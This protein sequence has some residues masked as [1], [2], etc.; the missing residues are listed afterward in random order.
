MARPKSHSTTSQPTHS[1]SPSVGSTATASSVGTVLF[2]PQYMDVPEPS[3]ISL[4]AANAIVSSYPAPETTKNII[5][6]DVIVTDAGLRTINLFLD[7]ILHEFLARGKST[8]L[9]RLREA[10]ALVIR[11]ALGTAAMVEAEQ[12]LAVNLHD[13]DTEL[14][15]AGDESDGDFEK[16]EAAWNLEKVWARA[17]V[18]CMIYSTLGDKEEEDFE[19][20]EEDEADYDIPASKRKLSAAGAIYLIAVLEFIGEHCFI[21]AARHAYHR[22][23]HSIKT[24]NPQSAPIPLTI[25][26]ADVKR[27]IAEDDL[28]TRLWRK[29]KRSEKLLSTM[30]IISAVNAERGDSSRADSTL[31]RLPFGPTQLARRSSIVSAPDMSRG[32]SSDT[33]EARTKSL[34]ISPTKATAEKKNRNRHSKVYFDSKTANESRRDSVS[35]IKETLG[36]R[37]VTLPDS[38]HSSGHNSDEFLGEPSSSQPNHRQS[39]SESDINGFASGT[40]KRDANSAQVEDDDTTEYHDSLTSPQKERF[41]RIEPVDDDLKTPTLEHPPQLNG[42]SKTE[43]KDEDAVVV[44]GDAGFDVISS[45]TLLRHSSLSGRLEHLLANDSISLLLPK[46]EHLGNLM[47]VIKSLINTLKMNQC[48]LSICQN[49]LNTRPNSTAM[50][51]PSKSARWHLRSQSP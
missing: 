20:E 38:P 14:Y 21:V 37:G 41:S 32:E 6:G 3:Y 19:E 7:Y 45:I 2:L 5:S 50:S 36:E 33:I 51:S 13:S 47:R 42:E 15:D 8:S 11:T 27:G 43:K 9:Y 31:T 40:S 16:N 18:K 22:L 34:P 1:T 30:S 39:F 17:R 28:T 48:R 29:W 10:V 23:A 49:H 26:D 35:N 12:E 24:T 4:E 25:E 44:G 46:K